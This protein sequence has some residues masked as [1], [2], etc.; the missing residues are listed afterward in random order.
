VTA[1]ADRTA[2]IWDVASRR[3]IAVL[4]G[5]GGALY[6]AA[7]SK[8]GNR[9]LTAS[10]DKTARVWDASGIPAGDILSVACALL[11]D[12]KLDDLVQLGQLA[13][14]KPICVTPPPPPDPPGT[15]ATR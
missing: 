4:K 12:T 1:S 3:E 15:V 14:D 13:I 7:F 10:G 11:P 8:D 9:I 6:S 5:H 2:L